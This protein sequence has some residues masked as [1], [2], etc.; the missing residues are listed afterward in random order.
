M[1][2][3]PRRFSPFPTT[4]IFNNLSSTVPTL[5]SLESKRNNLNS[6][7]VWID[8]WS[9]KLLDRSKL[10]FMASQLKQ[11]PRIRMVSSKSRYFSSTASVCSGH[12][13]K[14]LVLVL[15]VI[16]WA[17]IFFISGTLFIRRRYEMANQ[18]CF[19]PPMPR[20]A[21]GELFVFLKFWSVSPFKKVYK[22]P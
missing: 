8:V 7:F 3:C 17:A 1:A 21:L 13:Q 18:V 6:V 19:D 4:Q 15:C 9:K 12:N 16:T 11:L 14:K 5:T 10:I 22:V 20:K 2:L